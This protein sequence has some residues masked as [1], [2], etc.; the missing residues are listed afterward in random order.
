M[1]SN[2][3]HI[4]LEEVKCHDGTPVPPELE[5][6]W[7]E[8]RDMFDKVRDKW[9]APIE[10]VCG[11]RSKKWNK[12]LIREDRNRGSH[13]VASGSQHLFMKALDIRTS[14]KEDLPLLYRTIMA[15]YENGE[16]PELGGIAI[17]PFSNWI[18]IDTYKVDHL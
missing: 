18:H 7:N 12:K 14:K 9:N 13:Q 2:G 11:Y 4:T 5:T 17:Y 16:L 1:L 15:M 10:I 6:N 8:T 3:R